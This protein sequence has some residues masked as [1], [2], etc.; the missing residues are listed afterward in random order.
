MLDAARVKKG[1]TVL[2]IATGT[3][4]IAAAAAN[5]GAHAIGLDFSQAQV[6]LARSLYPHIEFHVAVDAIRIQRSP[7]CKWLRQS[8]STSPS[9]YFSSLMPLAKWLSLAFFQK[10]ASRPVPHRTIG[11]VSYAAGRR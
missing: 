9:R 8:V 10:W 3:G 6:D 7:A 2:D 11:R 1:S 5:R 4:Y